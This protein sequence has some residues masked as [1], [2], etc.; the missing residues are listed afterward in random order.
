MHIKNHDF[1]V[2]SIRLKKNLKIIKRITKIVVI[3]II[4]II[5]IIICKIK[6]KLI[7]VLSLHPIINKCTIT[8]YL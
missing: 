2:H 7:N 5:I 1:E 4:I 3:I 6:I 8:A